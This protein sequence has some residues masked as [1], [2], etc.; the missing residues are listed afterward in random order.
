MKPICTLF[1]MLCTFGSLA[2]AAELQPLMTTPEKSLLSESFSGDAIPAAFRTLQTPDAFRVADGNLQILWKPEQKRAT[3]GAFYVKGQNLTV[4]LSVKFEKTGTLYI[5]ID[6]YKEAFK[7]NTHLVRFSLSPERMAW[8]QHRGGPESKH[9]VS[10]AARAARE[11]KQP[12]PQATKEQLADPTFFRIE[13]L[14][15]QP[16]ECAVGQWHQVML[17]VNG[18]DL[19]A[20]VAGKTL[21]AVSTEA[22]GMK[23]RIGIGLTGR[24]TALVDD[25]RIWEN[26]RRP[27][28]ES[29]KAKLTTKP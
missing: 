14:T 24:V 11:A 8:D 9:A 22:E 6:G 10:E 12:I 20:Q 5:G 7:G 1:A 28:W 3:H 18:N 15:N 29:V 17:E 4:A 23:N 21:V 25:V 2:P 19:V 26:T 16:I 27:D 13:D